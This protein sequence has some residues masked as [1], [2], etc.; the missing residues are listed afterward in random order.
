MSFFT[1][2]KNQLIFHLFVGGLVGLLIGYAYSPIR[3]LL[4]L[5][6]YN[7]LMAFVAVNTYRIYKK[8]YQTKEN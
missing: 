4:F 5:V 8:R 3:G 2:Y 6:S 7:L 1:Y